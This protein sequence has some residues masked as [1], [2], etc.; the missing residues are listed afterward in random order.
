MGGSLLLVDV[1][2]DISL[3]GNQVRVFP[4]TSGL[5]SE[6]MQRL[7]R[8][9]N[10]SETVSSSRPAHDA[11]PPTPRMITRPFGTQ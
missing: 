5:R 2:P 8:E 11:R 10:F 3:E 7:A 4:D 6:Q 9:V 1:I